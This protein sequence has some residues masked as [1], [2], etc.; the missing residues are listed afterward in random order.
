MR[1]LRAAVDESTALQILSEGF[2]RRLLDRVRGDA[3][4][5]KSEMVWAPAYVVTIPMLERGTTV[6]FLCAVDALAGAFALFGMPEAIAPG[7]PE[8]E[9]FAPRLS[10]EE[11]DAIAR[12]SLVAATLRRR[13]KSATAQLGDTAS[14]ELLRW[15]YWVFYHRRPNGAMS[16]RVLDAATGGRVGHKIKLGLL[17]A[18]RAAASAN[19]HHKGKTS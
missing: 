4:P 9:Q 7:E 10:A 6:S 11:A 17:E 3:A 2:W 18:F 1:H 13:R 15:P 8:G 14:I 19:Q 12:A 5:V 16:I